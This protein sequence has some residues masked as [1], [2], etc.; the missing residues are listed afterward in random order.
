MKNIKFLFIAFLVI[1][2]GLVSCSSDD[3]NDVLEDLDKKRDREEYAKLVGTWNLSQRTLF[4]GDQEVYT[5][6][7]EENEYCE[8]KQLI[9]SINY[10]LQYSYKINYYSEGY[11][12]GGSS[13]YD[14]GYKDKVL[15][16]GNN[17]LKEEYEN[18]NL[19]SLEGD[20]MKMVQTV[21]VDQ[22]FLENLESNYK[23][24]AYDFVVGQ[25]VTFVDILLRE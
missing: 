5:K 15:Y 10:Y 19:T 9:I 16:W 1:S 22:D 6:E 21:H 3:N 14:V 7:Y 4:I 24:I 23:Y 12:R 18:Q 13:H 17:F 2:T 8:F 25:E 20:Q 11:C